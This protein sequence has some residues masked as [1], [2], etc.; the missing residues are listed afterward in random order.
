MIEFIDTEGQEHINPPLSQFMQAV[1]AGDQTEWEGYSG[2]AGIYWRSEKGDRRIIFTPGGADSY[3]LE[4]WDD[5]DGLNY[6]F[7]S[8]RT[9]SPTAITEVYVGG[10]PWPIP[11][12][13]FVPKADALVVLAHF[14]TT[15][16]R[17]DA[18]Q[19]VKNSEVNWPEE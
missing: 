11:A 17:S 5:S 2:Q 9:G 1:E 14:Y 18:I 13:L 7:V 16:E 6:Y 15:H 8:S 10:N 19:W 12:N 4:Y 3:L